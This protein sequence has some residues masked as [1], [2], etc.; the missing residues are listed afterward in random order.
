MVADQANWW[1]YELPSG[2][3]RRRH[4]NII[5]VREVTLIYAVTREPQTQHLGNKRVN[6]IEYGST[7]PSWLFRDTLWTHQ[8]LLLTEGRYLTLTSHFNTCYGSSHCWG[9]CCYNPYYHNC[10]ANVRVPDQKEPFLRPSRGLLGSLT[11]RISVVESVNVCE[12]DIW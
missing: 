11:T 7:R 4:R 8:E 5:Y 3:W 12:R 10:V 9:L 2:W 1:G 6:A